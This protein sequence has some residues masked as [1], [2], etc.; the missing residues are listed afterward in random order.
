MSE[1]KTIYDFTKVTRD[2][3]QVLTVITVRPPSHKRFEIRAGRV[4]VNFDRDRLYGR[5]DAYAEQGVTDFEHDSA[6]IFQIPITGFNI[7]FISDGNLYANALIL[8]RSPDALR[9]KLDSAYDPTKIDGAVK[10]DGKKYCTQGV[11]HMI[12]P[13][14]LWEGPKAAPGLYQ[15]L[16]G[17][18][19]EIRTIVGPLN[20]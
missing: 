10:C 3:K 20:E 11:P 1:E 14:D 5:L 19:L 12:V 4:N 9:L 13:E 17:A 16:V 18:R 7:E 6:Y 2:P 8:G 15:Q